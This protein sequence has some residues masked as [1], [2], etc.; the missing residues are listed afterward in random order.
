M[1]TII[2]DFIGGIWDGKSV[3]IPFFPEY[4]VAIPPKL[5][6]ADY[7]SNIEAIIG[8][9]GFDVAVYK[10]IGYGLYWLSRTEKR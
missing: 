2:A 6:P 10:Y 5:T 1:A 7:Q 3:S 8:N 4:H 9:T